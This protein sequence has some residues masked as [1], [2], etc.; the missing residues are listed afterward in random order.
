M[1]LSIYTCLRASALSGS[2]GQGRW[3]IGSASGVVARI[4]K[5]K[6]EKQSEKIEK[7]EE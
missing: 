2:A 7:A 6:D 4:S 1:I 3:W 5:N